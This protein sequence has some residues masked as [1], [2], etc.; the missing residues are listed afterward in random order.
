MFPVE[1]RGHR[2]ERGGLSFLI[3]AGGPEKDPRSLPMD[4]LEGQ[5]VI[6]ADGGLRL[7][8]ELGLHP[9]LLIG[10]LDTVSQAE[11]DETAARGTEIKKYPTN[12]NES[13]LELAI[14]AAK[15]LGADR[16]TLLGALGGQ[17]DHCLVN[18]L[19]PL[20]LCHRLGI[21]ARLLTA[22]CE[23]YLLT[24]GSYDVS[25]PPD[26]RISLAALS[27]EVKGVSLDGFHYP[28]AGESLFRHQ[29]RGLANQ[30]TSPKGTIT[31]ESGD[32]LL[33]VVRWIDSSAT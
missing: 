31:I 19:A 25:L 26:T 15:S 10:D 29:T 12:K 17:W 20:S 11:V 1:R 3:V 33:T 21:W 4:Q 23:I 22:T 14:L 13:D 8:R 7:C 18:L 27:Q 2:E 6:A 30:L 9:K 5:P 24:P 32:L 16:M 28:L